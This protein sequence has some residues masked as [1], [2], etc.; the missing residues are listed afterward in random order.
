[1]W[2]VCLNPG[3]CICLSMAMHLVRFYYSVGSRRFPPIV[4]ILSRVISSCTI[5][6]YTQCCRPA[7]HVA[8]KLRL[9]TNRIFHNRFLLLDIEVCS[10]LM[11]CFFEVILLLLMILLFK[12]TNTY[13]VLYLICS[14]A[15]FFGFFPRRCFL[16]LSLLLCAVVL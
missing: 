1:M 2:V 5:F 13:L 8:V 11:S 10:S 9:A 3:S 14:A 16:Q 7:H 4:V 6:I 12:L 15:A